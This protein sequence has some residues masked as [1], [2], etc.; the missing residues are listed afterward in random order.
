MSVKDVPREI[1]IIH[2]IGSITNPYLGCR[3]VSGEWRRVVCRPLT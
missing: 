3:I 2:R 1:Y